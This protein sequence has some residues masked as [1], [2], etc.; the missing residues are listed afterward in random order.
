MRSTETSAQELRVI[1]VA[2]LEELRLREISLDVFSS[3]VT[4]LNFDPR[5]NDEISY[6]DPNLAEIIEDIAP[7]IEVEPEFANEKLERIRHLLIDR[8]AAKKES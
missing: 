6:V 7:D 3:A 1:I 8:R 4:Q 5:F 2:L